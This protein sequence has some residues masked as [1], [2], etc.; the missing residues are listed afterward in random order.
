M[1]INENREIDNALPYYADASDKLAHQMHNLDEALLKIKDVLDYKITTDG[2]TYN[3]YMTC[4]DYIRK[5]FKCT[6]TE[7]T[8]IAWHSLKNLNLI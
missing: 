4:V 7:A 2:D 6:N 3:F 5:E 1:N 8:R